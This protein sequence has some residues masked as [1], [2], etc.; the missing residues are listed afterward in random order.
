MYIRDEAGPRETTLITK[1]DND[2]TEQTTT[3]DKQRQIDAKRD[4]EKPTLGNA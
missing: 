1:N 3:S 4:Q 2:N